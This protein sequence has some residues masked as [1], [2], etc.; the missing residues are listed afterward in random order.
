MFYMLTVMLGWMIINIVLNIIAFIFGLN[1]SLTHYFLIYII[2]GYI[3]M[4]VKQIIS[5][6]YQG[7]EIKKT[8][9]PFDSFKKIELKLFFKD[10]YYASWWPYYLL[11]KKQ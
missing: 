11:R 10:V 3:V 2:I 6:L 5:P 8:G 4:S 1:F 9:N 7:S